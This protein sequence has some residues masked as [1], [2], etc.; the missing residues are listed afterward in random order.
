MRAS[1]FFLS[2][3]KE[4]PSDAEVISHKLMMRAGLIKRLAG[5]IYTW[6]PLGLRA[7]RKVEAIVKEE[8]NRAGAIELLMPAVQPAELWQESGRWDFYGPELLRFKDRHD[9]DFVI[10]PTHE[11]VITDV[12]RRDLRSY[13]QLPKHFYQVQMKFRD[14]IRPRFGVMR[15]REF[16]MKD[17]YSFHSSFEDLQREYRNM[18][19]TYHRIFNRLGLKFRAV[20]ADTG[21]IGGTGSHE[22]HVIAETGEDDIAY[23]PTSDYAA[24]VEL[25][26]A[27]A[28]TTPRPDATAALTKVHTPGVK[29]IDELAAFLKVPATSTVKAIVVDGDDSTGN[30]PVLLLLRGDHE[31][32]EVKAQ[33]IAG[34]KNP[35]TFA[36]PAA[37]L[38]AFGANAGSLG[39]VGF[40]GRVVM[41]RSVAAMA[42][43]V[44]GANEDDH[45][46]TGV[47]IGRDFP[48]AEVADLRNVVAGDPSPDGQGTL[49]IC[50][51]IEVGHIFQLRTKYAEALNCKFLNEQGK[52]QIMEMG[53]YGIGVSRILG[54]AI[55]QN[56]DARGI[57]WPDAIA[58]FQV[59]IVPMGYAKSDAVRDAA[60]ALYTELVAAG[61]D[62]FLDDRDERPGSLLADNELIG[63]PHRVVIGDRGLKEGVVEYQ[64]RR[65]AEATK[66]ALNE[67]ASLVIGKLKG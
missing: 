61:I 2:T 4:A 36:S 30:K 35:L 25:A 56:N 19:D 63:T 39:P 38:A 16:L 22:F 27:L 8:M 62:A 11:E 47:N 52:E 10:G 1:Q 48:E 65:D 60:N 21:S 53:C 7:L 29:T 49:E 46:Y 3:L 15:G 40:E 12:V 23:C 58:P 17:G 50:R 51:G 32:N 26:E 14:E 55:E 31:L 9:R 18:Y 5:G 45:H 24:N 6:M 37:I 28:P 33:K 42:D 13:R 34:V 43:F 66:L 41:D 67:V 59:A 54:A 57:I 20:A 64:G 44:T